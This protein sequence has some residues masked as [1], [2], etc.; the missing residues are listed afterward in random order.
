MPKWAQECMRFL[1]AHLKAASYCFS[2]ISVGVSL[3]SSS[4]GRELACSDAACRSVRGSVAQRI[5]YVT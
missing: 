4:S 1:A 2:S 3:L 5:Q